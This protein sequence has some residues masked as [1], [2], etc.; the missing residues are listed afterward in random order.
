MENK[1]RAIFFDNTGDKTL[2]EHL[3]RLLDQYSYEYYELNQTNHLDQILKDD[4]ITFL[5][6]SLKDSVPD[7]LLMI[8]TKTRN[9]AH[10]R[11]SYVFFRFNIF[12][13]G[14]VRKALMC[15]AKEVYLSPI[16][17]DHIKKDIK[18]Y[19]RGKKRRAAKERPLEIHP[20]ATAHVTSFGRI[21]KISKAEPGVIYAECNAIM[22]EKDAVRINNPLNA[23]WGDSEAIWSVEETK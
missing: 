17:F 21:G 2:V 11:R 3:T 16:D 1:G 22:K 23:A 14:V 19:L 15:G 12:D 5:F 7:E 13:P 9:L 20:P 6:I 8:L 18:Y 4:K 10:F